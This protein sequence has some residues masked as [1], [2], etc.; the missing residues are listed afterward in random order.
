M[1][2]GGVTVVDNEIPLDPKTEI[3]GTD[4]TILDFWQWGFSNILTNSLRGI[5]AEFLVGSA[6]GALNLPRIEWDAFDLKFKDKKIEVKSAAYIQAWYRGTLSKIS[7]NIGAKKEYDYNTNTYSG[8]AARNADIFTFCL[9]KEKDQELIN[10]M[11]TSQWE[12]YVV[13]TGE[14]NKLYPHQKTIS[15]SSL[16][17]ICA[18]ILYQDL[19]YVMNGIVQ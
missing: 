12:F 8:E 3:A 17:K 14:L 5:F 15:L 18:P 10:P 6:L 7:F 1:T 4:L 11:D 2:K 13:T 16:R 9:L 19:K